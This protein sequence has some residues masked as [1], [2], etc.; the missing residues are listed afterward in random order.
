MGS[1][2]I[3]YAQTCMSENWKKVQ[4]NEL[5][6][7]KLQG[8]QMINKQC[9][10]ELQTQKWNVSKTTESS[11]TLSQTTAFV[12]VAATYFEETLGH[13]EGGE[14]LKLIQL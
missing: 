2:H 4:A 10:K 7:D 3:M 9:V 6:N 13:L 5:Q 14:R 11:T 8:E 12:N 1:M